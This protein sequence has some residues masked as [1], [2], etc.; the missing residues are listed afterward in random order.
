MI[1]ALLAIGSALIL[2]VLV[3]LYQHSEIKSLT[4]S[5]S[6]YNSEIVQLEADAEQE[7]AKFN[8]AQTVA[9]KQV[10]NIQSNTNKIMATKVSPTCDK[11][12]SW[13]RNEAKTVHP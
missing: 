4:S 9:Y 12:M 1:D 8:A 11:A 7:K 3:I 10:Q 5:N 2:A 6:F 13:L